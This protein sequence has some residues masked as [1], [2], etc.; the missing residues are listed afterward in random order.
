MAPLFG[1]AQR[2]KSIPIRHITH[3]HGASYQRF[4]A[5]SANIVSAA[6]YKKPN[7]IIG[8]LHFGLITERD[9][10]IFKYFLNGGNG[11]SGNKKT[12]STA[13]KMIGFSVDFGYYLINQK[14]FAIYPLAGLG[15]DRYTLI[16]NR[17]NSVIPFDSVLQ[18]PATRQRTNP[19]KLSNTFFHYRIGAGIKFNSVKHPRNS[20]GFDAGYG[21]S[22]KGNDWKI[23]NTQTL[24]Q[25]PNEKLSKYFALILISYRLKKNMP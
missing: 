20:I 9:K 5:I 8:T 17:D 11:F 21:S 15:Y 22:F 12:Q 18:N 1:T 7:P 2:K 13:T 16:L 10:T 23:N 24:A 6:N 4:P 3:A 14:R 19:V 25:S